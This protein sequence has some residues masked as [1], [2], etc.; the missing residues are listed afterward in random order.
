MRMDQFR[1]WT[2]PKASLLP[3][4]LLGILVLFTYFTLQ[5]YGPESTLRKFHSALIRIDQAQAAGKKIPKADWNDLRSTLVEDLGDVEG[6]GDAEAYGA[7]RQVN[8]LLLSGYTYSLAKMDRL[9]REVR[10][11]VTYEKP[12]LPPIQMVWIVDKSYGGREWKISAR[13]TLSA[14]DIP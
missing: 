3:A 13:K 5:N 12:K 11:A 4:I 6:T 1:M 9:T 7:I 2:V 8:E 14:M 10:I